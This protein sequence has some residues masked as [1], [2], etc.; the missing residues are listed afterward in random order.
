VRIFLL[1]LQ[2]LARRNWAE[3]ET[4]VAKG[5]EL[6]ENG[7]TALRV[8]FGTGLA[9]ALLHLKRPAEKVMAVADVRLPFLAVC[10]PTQVKS[11]LFRSVGNTVTKGFG[12]GQ[13]V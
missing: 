11:C 1:A 4:E 2:I 3:I 13:R 9:K 5:L 10:W 7:H 6:L 8:E 12:V